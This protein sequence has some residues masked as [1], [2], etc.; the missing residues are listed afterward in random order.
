MPDPSRVHLRVTL[1][2]DKATR[3]LES[4]IDDL[5]ALI[6]GLPEWGFESRNQANQLLNR[7]ERLIHTIQVKA[8]R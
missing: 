7:A 4:L 5:G 2:R 3:E 8:I 1:H 6:D